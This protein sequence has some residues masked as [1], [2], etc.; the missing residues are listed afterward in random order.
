MVNWDHLEIP[1]EMDNLGE[2]DSRDHQVRL[3]DQVPQ[4]PGAHQVDSQEVEG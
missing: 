3:V 2:M 1:V 4:V